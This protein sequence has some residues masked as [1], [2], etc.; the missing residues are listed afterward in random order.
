[1]KKK[2]V[3]A[4]M[5][6]LIAIAGIFGIGRG[7]TV[8]VYRYWTAPYQDYDDSTSGP[9]SFYDL[10]W[11]TDSLTEANFTQG[12][13]VPGEPVPSQPGQI[14]SCTIAELPPNTIVFFAIKSVDEAGNVS[15][16]S[17]VYKQKTPDRKKP[18]PITDLR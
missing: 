8:A 5:A 13:E 12:N 4:L 7:Q 17:N 15:D 11:D 18:K 6:I 10:R 3:G 2:I 16:I 9:V 1:V 14:D